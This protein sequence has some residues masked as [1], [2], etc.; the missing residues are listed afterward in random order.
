MK[1]RECCPG[2]TKMLE[3]DLVEFAPASLIKIEIRSGAR[4]FGAR[5]MTQ[6]RPQAVATREAFE[7]VL[8]SP[9]RPIRTLAELRVAVETRAALDAAAAQHREELRQEFIQQPFGVLGL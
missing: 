7:P 8:G 4:P 6:Q 3:D 2:E 9:R 1:A 5:A